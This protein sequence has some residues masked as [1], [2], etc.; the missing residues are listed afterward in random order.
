MVY[1]SFERNGVIALV[2]GGILSFLAIF[3]LL[4]TIITFSKKYSNTHFLLYFYCLLLA[5]LMQAFGSIMSS[6]WVE[7]GG[8]FEGPFCAAQ[9]LRPVNLGGIKQGGNIAAAF[10][11][12]QISLH[13]F[14]LS[15]R[16]YETT[17]LVSWTVVAFG[18]SFVFTMVFLG[19]VAMEKKAE[20]GPFFGISGADP[21]AV[22]LSYFCT[23]QPCCGARKHL[24]SRR[25]LETT[26]P[27]RWRVVETRVWEGFHRLRVAAS[28]T[29]HDLVSGT[30]SGS[31]EVARIN[32]AQVAYAVCMLPIAIV[33]VSEFAGMQPPFAVTVV[34]AFIFNLSGLVDVVLFFTMHRVFPEE[35]SLPKFT[36]RKTVDPNVM[37][38]G[39]TPF[40][41]T[42]PS[43]E[44]PK[45]L[46]PV[47][48]GSGEKSEES[49]GR[50]GSTGSMA[51]INSQTPLRAA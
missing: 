35:G 1:S 36:R 50:R 44:E 15:F 42:Q 47:S 32:T 30:S 10:W 33:R 27:P 46:S 29:T 7:H 34:A 43:G 51:S 5:D 9:D 25:S 13:L 6:H 49:G 18:W 26:L 22:P 4:L 23:L 45:P 16:R 48:E 38:H 24:E 17:K 12:F 41:F 19:P 39:I 8:V 21:D 11:T 2:A 28:H 20:L 3:Y 40:A 31:I 14:N 37:Q